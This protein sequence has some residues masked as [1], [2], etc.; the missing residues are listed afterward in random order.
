MTP[1]ERAD[2]ARKLRDAQIGYTKRGWATIEL[3]PPIQAEAIAT[4]AERRSATRPLNKSWPDLAVDPRY[5]IDDRIERIVRLREEY[6]ALGIG[7]VMGPQLDGHRYHVAIDEDEPDAL[8]ALAAQHG[9]I[10]TP[11]WRQA[12][13]RGSH[14]V[15]AL[16]SR[17]ALVVDLL[18]GRGGALHQ[19]LPGIDVLGARKYIVGAPSTHRDGE[20]RY[21]IVDDLDPV[22][23][24]DWIWQMILI[25]ATPTRRQHDDP[26]LTDDEIDMSWPYAYR[27][28]C[29]ERLCETHSEAIQGKPSALGVTGWPTTMRLVGSIVS[30]LALGRTEAERSDVIEIVMR[31]YSP[32]CR[33]AW[34]RDE[35]E[36]MVDRAIA[37]PY[38]AVG[39]LLAQQRDAG[40]GFG[41]GGQKGESGCSAAT[42][43][44]RYRAEILGVDERPGHGCV[45]YAV[46]DGPRAGQKR[47]RPMAW[48]PT[49]QSRLLW[50]AL[51]HAVGLDAITS[52]HVQLR[53]RV[54]QIEIADGTV[55]RIGH[56][57]AAAGTEA[58]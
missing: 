48:P 17:Q 8:S 42:A 1:R 9:E 49:P 56:V 57:Y 22:E 44:P 5:S 30:G 34:D 19:H 58:S 37:K 46:L 54:V 6:T 45:W 35:I 33:P 7:L 52:P 43:A 51:A 53:G 31:A 15:Y 32:R 2:R 14:Y 16:T 23:L 47:P 39:W 20:H 29:A 40:P 4:D 18:H 3:R 38:R 27:L 26:D 55:G 36:A 24:P 28:R 11:T 50:R 12:A 41:H 25:A 10:V 21:A 13:R